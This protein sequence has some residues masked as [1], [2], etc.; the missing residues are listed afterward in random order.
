MTPS[1]PRAMIA[2]DDKRMLSSTFEAARRDRETEAP[3]SGRQQSSHNTPASR[4]P[5]HGSRRDDRGADS[6]VPSANANATASLASRIDGSN[7]PPRPA[8]DHVWDGDRSDME[9][10]RKRT[11]SARSHDD[12][13]GNAAPPKRVKINRNFND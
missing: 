5:P 2:P 3:P 4:A 10:Q 9:G 7:L 6:Y 11:A 13:A 8:F 12:I 1:A